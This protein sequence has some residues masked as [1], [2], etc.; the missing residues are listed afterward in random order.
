MD[1]SGG[2]ATDSAL[3]ARPRGA[4]VTPRSI[5]PRGGVADC[6]AC[7]APPHSTPTGDEATHAGARMRKFSCRCGVLAVWLSGGHTFRRER[8]E[9]VVYCDETGERLGSHAAEEGA[10]AHLVELLAA[11]DERPSDRR[12]GRPGG[13]PERATGA[14]A[15]SGI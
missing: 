1:V 6:P 13:P 10:R 4:R 8:G 12:G 3:W 2:E 15:P 7:E 9:F 14:R 5:A 11:A